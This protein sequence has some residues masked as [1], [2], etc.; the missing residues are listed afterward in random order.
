MFRHRSRARASTWPAG[1][2]RVSAD[3]Q[4]RPPEAGRRLLDRARQA[5]PVPKRRRKRKVDAEDQ[6]WSGAGADGRDPAR[7]GDSLTSLVSDRNWEDSLRTA[8][9]PARWEQ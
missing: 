8:G 7:L 5:P 2:G 3:D 4:E 6:P 9:I 1:R